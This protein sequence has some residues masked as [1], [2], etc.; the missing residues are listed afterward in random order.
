MCVCA[1][2][3]T[4]NSTRRV[5]SYYTKYEV[6]RMHFPGVDRKDRVAVTGSVLDM[7]HQTTKVAALISRET[8]R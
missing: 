3:A 4:V 5:I 2:Q 7:T 1:F 6:V 8:L